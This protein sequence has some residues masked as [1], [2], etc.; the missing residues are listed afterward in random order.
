M[1]R[2]FTS[3]FPSIKWRAIKVRVFSSSESEVAAKIEDYC[4]KMCE[5]ADYYQA[6]GCL[7]DVSPEDADGE[8][9]CP[10][11]R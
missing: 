6:H 8:G 7:P 11:E 2:T 3:D 4:T 1:P 10:V 5:W 9:D